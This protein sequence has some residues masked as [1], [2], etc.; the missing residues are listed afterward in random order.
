ML[1]SDGEP[2]KIRQLKSEKVARLERIHG[3]VLSASGVRAKA[4]RMSIMCRSCRSVIPNIAVKPGFE[5]YA[6]PRKCATNQ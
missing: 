6:L 2:G 5:G 1:I 4:T 3:I